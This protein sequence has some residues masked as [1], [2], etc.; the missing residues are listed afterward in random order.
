MSESTSRVVKTPEWNAKNSASQKG[1]VIPNDVKGKM[2]VSAKIR[3]DRDGNPMDRPEVRAKLKEPRK[4]LE[5][6][7]VIIMMLV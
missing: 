3:I 7:S 6:L 1:K 5:S 2:S 4:P